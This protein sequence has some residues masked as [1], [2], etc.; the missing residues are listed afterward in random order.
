MTQSTSARMSGRQTPMSIY[1]TA[2]FL[3][4]TVLNVSSPHL[5]LQPAMEMDNW[6]MRQWVTASDPLTN[7]EITAQ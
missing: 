3:V 7:D 2:T 1:L 5:L 4:S 6:V